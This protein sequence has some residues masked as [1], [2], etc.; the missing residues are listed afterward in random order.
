MIVIVLSTFWVLVELA[1]IYN[2]LFQI[3]TLNAGG[4]EEDEMED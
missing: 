1:H 4:L 3:A 2:V